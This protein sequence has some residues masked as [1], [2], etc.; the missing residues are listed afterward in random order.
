[1]NDYAYESYLVAAT[2]SSCDISKRGMYQVGTL[3]DLECL[4]L[5]RKTEIVSSAPSRAS[6]DV[7]TV[8]L[9]TEC[10]IARSKPYKRPRREVNLEPDLSKALW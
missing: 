2:V 10:G 8:A 6:D 1:M 4:F 3:S 9:W 5:F 7:S